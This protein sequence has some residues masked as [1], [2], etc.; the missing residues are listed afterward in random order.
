MPGSHNDINVLQRSTLFARLAEGQAPEVNYTINGH[1]Y[2]MGYYLT[3]GIYPS[4]ATFVKTIP[5]PQ[6]NKK[7]YFALAQESYRK[8]VERAFG[9][10]QARFAIV[11]GPGHFWDDDTL[12][13]IMRACVIMHNKII[14]DERDEEDDFNYDV[15]GENVKISHD[16][17]PEFEEFI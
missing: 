3:D 13:L 16:S 9:V 2:T 8:D 4:W 5:E 14:E 1:N 11:R 12:S 17:T 7:K 15:V 10:L 6:G